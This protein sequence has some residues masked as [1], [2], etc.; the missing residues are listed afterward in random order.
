MM[1]FDVMKRMININSK[2][3]IFLFILMCFNKDVR[4]IKYIIIEP[5]SGS[6]NVSIEG[7]KVI[8]D[9]VSNDLFFIR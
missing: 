9:R 5:V 1:M 2:G 8:M 6:K 4:M 3:A 7:I